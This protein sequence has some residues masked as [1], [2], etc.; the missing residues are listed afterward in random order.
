[1]RDGTP[2]RVDVT[3]DGAPERLGTSER[4]SFDARIDVVVAVPA[5]PR[6]VG[7][8]D[9]ERTEESPGWPRPGPD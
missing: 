4:I 1:M 6:G 8:V 9:G 2:A 7:D 3:G 5:G